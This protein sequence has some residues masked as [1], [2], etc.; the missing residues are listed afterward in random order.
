MADEWTEWAYARVV[1]Q[2]DKDKEPR[3]LQPPGYVG[4][5]NDKASCVFCGKLFAALVDRVRYHVAGGAGGAAAG[6]TACPGP[7]ERDE[8]S[9]AAF[10]ERKA[11]FGAPSVLTAMAKVK[12]DKLE[13]EHG[14]VGAL[15]THLQQLVLDGDFWAET[16]WRQRQC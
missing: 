13:G 14:T 10:A 8:E 2:A 3:V 16:E 5:G 6:I 4:C 12:N 1:L 11:T 7:S 15:F 9:A